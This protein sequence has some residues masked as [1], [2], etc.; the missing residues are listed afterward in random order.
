MEMI[1]QPESC[2]GTSNFLLV[3]KVSYMVA[4][5]DLLILIKALLKKNK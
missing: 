1:N 5:N 3:L 2:Y 4:V